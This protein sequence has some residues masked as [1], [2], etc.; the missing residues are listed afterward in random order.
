M[1]GNT[2]VQQNNQE[3]YWSVIQ[4]LDPELYLIRIAIQETGINPMILPKII[5][6]ISN[7]NIGT[8]YGR[9][10][11]FMTN[12]K[13]TQVKNEESDTLNENATIDS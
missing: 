13:V 7:L 4:Q 2:T 3:Q 11:V 9:V 6:A 12:H 1:N 10:Q 8:G 5:R